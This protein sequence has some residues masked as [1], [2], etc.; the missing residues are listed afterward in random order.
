M[1]VGKWLGYVLLMILMS[2]YFFPFEIKALP[3][4]N[5]KMLMAGLGLLLVP[6][7]LLTGEHEQGRINMDFL[8]LVLWA[9]L[10]SFIGYISIVYN[11][12]QDYGYATYIVSMLVWLSAANIVVEAIRRYHGYVSVGLLFDYL[13]GVCVMQCV[14]A[15]LIQSVP[16]FHSLANQIMTVT[17]AMEDRLYGIDASLD[18]AGTRFS[19]V[20]IMIAYQIT[21]L[22]EGNSG[23]MIWYIFMAVFIVVVGNMI[24]RTTTVGVFFFIMYL[25]YE[26]WVIP[27]EMGTMNRKLFYYF[28]GII[29]LITPIFIYLYHTDL[30]F[31]ENLRFGFEGFFSLVEKGKW[32]VHSNEI[33]KNMY[34]FPDNLKTWIIGDGY[35]DGTESVD[36][37]YIGEKWKIGFY[38]GTDVGYLRFIFYFGLTGLMAFSVFMCKVAQVCMNR[39]TPYKSLFFVILLLN[40]AVWFKVSTDIFLVFALFLCMTE[41]EDQMVKQEP[42]SDKLVS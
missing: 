22:R 23:K 34:V 25:L 3:G 20:L 8:K 33:L 13:I 17:R 9:I 30:A 42:L 19:A 16:F 10:V 7:Q 11:E 28:G 36:P 38:K 2:L 1:K 35:F 18:I 4:A 26:R 6:Y 32:E 31:Q 14:L 24:S 21:H 29:L 27:E 12:T 40:F 39:F 5:T 41:T 37:Y 15:L